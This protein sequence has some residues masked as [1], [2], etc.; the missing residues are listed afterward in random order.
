MLSSAFSFLSYSA[1]PRDSSQSKIIRF[2]LGQKKSSRLAYL[3][4]LQSMNNPFAIFLDACLGFLLKIVCNQAF[5]KEL[6]PGSARWVLIFFFFF[7]GVECIL[8]R[9][10]IIWVFCPYELLLLRT[11]HGSGHSLPTV[12]I[13]ISCIQICI[14]QTTSIRLLPQLVRGTS[15]EPC[16]PKQHRVGLSHQSSCIPQCSEAEHL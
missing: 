12:R 1:S 10:E 2:T 6:K 7:Q 11:K 15:C 16:K 13:C 9:K 8:A 14:I 5:Y 3:H 4:L